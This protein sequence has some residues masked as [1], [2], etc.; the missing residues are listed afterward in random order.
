[1]NVQARSHQTD[2]SADA[3]TVTDVLP[4]AAILFGFQFLVIRKR[5][6][7]LKK[8]LVG[9]AYVLIAVINRRA[10]GWQIDMAVAPG[11][12]V[13]SLV[14]AVLTALLAG[15]YPARRAARSEPALAMR[16]E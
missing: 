1:M 7:N 4:I 14:F 11:I 13:T 6:P 5:P 2:H 12:L 8:V 9:V 16:E 3:A 15:V 10:F